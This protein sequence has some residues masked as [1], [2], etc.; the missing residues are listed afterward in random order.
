MIF[1]NQG[2]EKNPYYNIGAFYFPLGL[3]SILKHETLVAKNKSD[4]I[5]CLENLVFQSEMTSRDKEHLRDPPKEGIFIHGLY[6]WGCHWEKNGS[7][8]IGKFSVQK[9]NSKIFHLK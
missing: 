4:E 8:L 6:L 7:E 5:G 1:L 9:I 3:L 2:R